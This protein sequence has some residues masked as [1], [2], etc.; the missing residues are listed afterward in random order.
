MIMSKCGADGTRFFRQPM[1]DKMKIS[2]EYSKYF[3]GYTSGPEALTSVLVR[4]ST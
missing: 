4:V 2:Q 3:N 1:E